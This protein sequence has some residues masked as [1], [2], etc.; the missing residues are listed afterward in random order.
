M[1][2]RNYSDEFD[3]SYVDATAR[4]ALYDDMKSAPRVTEIAPATTNEFIEHLTTTVYEQSRLVG[5]KVPYTLIREVSENFI[6]AQF[7][8]IVVSILDDGNTIRFADQGPGIAEKERAQKPG[9]SSA[10]EPMKKYIRGVGSGF[11]IVK[12]YLDDR[13][14]SIVIED[15][16]I[17][18]AGVTISLEKSRQPQI[19][20]TNT[21]AKGSIEPPHQRQEHPRPMALP[22]IP[23]TEREKKFLLA[24]LHEGELGVT[25]LKD[26]TDTAA[27]TTFNTLKKLEEAGLVE[28]TVGKKRWLTELGYQFAVQIEA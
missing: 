11:P 19:D 6:H 15:N 13:D 3:Y 26:L 2:T 18:G 21:I 24:L 28:K 17:S 4:V 1:A 8:E 10:I 7:R 25:E 22:P 9:F 27:S 5:G 14:G 20:K 12:D 23:L 16:L